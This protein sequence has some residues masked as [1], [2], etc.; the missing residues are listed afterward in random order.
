MA[1]GR[2]PA[3][4]DR[5]APFF[6]MIETLAFGKALQRA[7]IAFL[8]ETR[9]CQRALVAG[10]GNGR[11]LAELLRANPKIQIDYVDSS[12]A[13]MGL[14]KSIVAGA[15]EEC[16][17]KIFPHTHAC[18]RVQFQQADV[19]DWTP[20]RPGYDLIVTH[21]FLDCFD[22]K[23]LGTVIQQIVAAAGSEARWLLSDFAIPRCGFRRVHAKLWLRTMYAFF[24]RAAH[25]EAGDLIDPSPLM[26]SFGFELRQRIDS[27][28]GLI[29]AQLWQIQRVKFEKNL[30][31]F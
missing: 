13:M 17:G 1:M 30:V 16:D 26:R 15:G 4:F 22:R 2:E 8:T 27:R 12:G 25:I 21:F 29:T 20:T 6:E 11:F 10:E 28:F 24:R 19:R 5:I 9:D 18:S 7:R 3:N 23:A 14:A 31:L